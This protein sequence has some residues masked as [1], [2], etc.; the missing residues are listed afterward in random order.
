M[1][2]NV[3]YTINNMRIFHNLIKRQL[4]LKYSQSTNLLDLACGK[5]GD[6]QKWLQCEFKFIMAI[7]SNENSI[8]ARLKTHNYD[9]AISRWFNIKKKLNSFIPFIRFEV[10]DILDKNILEHI[11]IKDN[12]KTYDTISC[13][14]AL[15]YF[16]NDKKNLINLFKLVSTKLNQGGYFIATTTNGNKIKSLLDFSG[17]FDSYILKMSNNTENKRGY[18]Y[19]LEENKTEI[20]SRHNYF[21]LEGISKEYFIILEE[22]LEIIAMPNIN[23]EL[24]EYKNFEDY[25][26]DEDIVS[27]LKKFNNY[28]LNQEEKLISFLN[29]A[30]VLKKK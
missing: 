18:Y 17:K 23:L 30:I 15:H 1:S 26:I 19:Y 5:G 11:N 28:P 2:D 27:K 9:G 7:D 6:I 24:V 20:D 4:Y 12:Y 3:I 14:F 13:H 10:L 25:Y 8:K 29:I 21:E 22:L 16:A